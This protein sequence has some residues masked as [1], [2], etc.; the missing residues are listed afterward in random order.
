MPV[1]SYTDRPSTSQ[2]LTEAPRLVLSI[3]QPWAWL[4]IHAGKDVENRTWPTRI[5]GRI[6]IHAAKTLTQDD[7]IAALL[8]CS[9]IGV[10]T[11]G[12]PRME[13]LDRGGLVGSVTL[14]GCVGHSASPWFCGPYG[15]ELRDPA[16][17]S[18][19]PARGRLGFFSV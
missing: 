11:R 14:T 13:Q 18:F 16:P 2:V 9:S 7:Y 1:P 5:R 10:D 12:V 19:A 8:L 3:R 15:F 17:I 4:I 6:Y